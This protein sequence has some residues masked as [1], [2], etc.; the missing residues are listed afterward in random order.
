MRVPGAQVDE[1]GARRRE[2]GYAVGTRFRVPSSRFRVPGSGAQGCSC[3]LD[4]R[5]LL[6]ALVV[7]AAVPFVFGLVPALVASRPNLVST[8]HQAPGRRRPRRGPYDG[9]DLL[10]IVEIGVAVVLLVCAGMFSRFFAELGRVQWGF[11]PGRVLAVSLQ[12]RPDAKGRETDALRVARLLA[13]VERLPGVESAASGA[14]AG[15]QAA[16]RAGDAIELEGC[17]ASPGA[18]GA[19]VLPV[20]APRATRWPWRVPFAPRYAAPTA[21]SP[22]R[23][24][25]ASTRPCNGDWR[26]PPS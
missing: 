23:S 21:R 14:V 25:G 3:T 6:F 7:T 2:D 18:V 12:P 13:E 15:F 11:D 9:R 16:L 22:S 10:V 8:L 20:D 19:V 24:S 4:A 1:K 26:V 5:A 17:A